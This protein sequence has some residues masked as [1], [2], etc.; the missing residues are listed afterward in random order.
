MYVD[1]EDGLRLV[2]QRCRACGMIAFPR[3]R[4]CPRCF[5]EDLADHTLSLVGTLHTYT[6]TYTGAPHLPK[7]YVLGFV[8]VPE[9]IRLLALIVDG[10]ECGSEL[11]VGMR[12]EMT[13][14]P[15]KVDDEGNT[16]Y[17]YMFRPQT[18]AEPAA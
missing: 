6:C 16:L 10:G 14:R 1:T 15:L 2:G 5:A 11:E 3:K 8:D 4:V 13:M 12:M 9:G 17:S 18:R 7:P